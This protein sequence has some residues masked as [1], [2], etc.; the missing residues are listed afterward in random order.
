MKALNFNKTFIKE[1]VLFVH[2][3]LEATSTTPAA[4]TT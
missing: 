2:S 1:H 4:A 3:S